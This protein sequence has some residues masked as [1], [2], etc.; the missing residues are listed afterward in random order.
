MLDNIY[1]YS[2]SNKIC[3]AY[4]LGEV[5]GIDVAVQLHNLGYTKISLFTSDRVSR[6]SLPSYVR[7]IKQNN[8]DSFYKYLLGN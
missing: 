6:D 8:L 4:D 3:L 5:N 2:K 7:Y 1:R